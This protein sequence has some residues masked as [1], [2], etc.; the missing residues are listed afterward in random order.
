[1]AGSS[2]GALGR[3]SAPVRSILVYG[4]DETA[5]VVFATSLVQRTAP[6]FG[7]ADCAVRASRIDPGVRAEIAERATGGLF[8]AIRREDFLAP[9]PPAREVGRLLVADSLSEEERRRMLAYLSLPP[10]LQTVVARADPDPSRAAVLLTGLQRVPRRRFAEGLARPETLATLRE[11]GVTL[12]A[13][14]CGI[15][16][17]ELR[18]VLELEMEVVGGAGGRPWADA[19]AMG[20]NPAAVA[21]YPSELP[22]A[23]VARRLGF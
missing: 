10:V 1:M 12:V 11:I 14:Y 20:R 7:W 8:E 9:S 13:T 19:R 5:T 6:S 21:A 4:L 18:D 23:A 22:V 3:E 16:P 2:N 15:P 17:P